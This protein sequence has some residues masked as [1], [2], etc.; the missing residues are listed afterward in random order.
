MYTK[1]MLGV[2]Q[3]QAA[4]SAM[5]A[6]FKEDPTRRPIAMAIVD[7]RGELLSYLRTDGC[8]PLAAKSCTKKAYASAISRQNT[9][10]YGERLKSQGRTVAESGDPMMTAVQGGLVITSADGATLGGIGVGGL[11]GGH[12]DEEIAQVGLKALNL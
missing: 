12:L 2:D 1:Q 10:D 5:L 6:N 8:G 11:P 3:C 7:D 4:I 9:V